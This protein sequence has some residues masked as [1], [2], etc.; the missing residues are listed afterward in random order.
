LSRI[1][2]R[3]KRPLRARLRRGSSCPFR[4]EHRLPLLGFDA[5]HAAHGRGGETPLSGPFSSL[6][7]IVKHDRAIGN[8]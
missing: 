1:R 6:T 3:G 7:S 4:F 8:D 5:S 2:T